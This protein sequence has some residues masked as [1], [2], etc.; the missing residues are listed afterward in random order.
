MLLN[1]RSLV[2]AQDHKYWT[3]G[4]D[5]IQKSSLLTIT[6]RRVVFEPRVYATI[7]KHST[8]FQTVSLS[9]LTISDKENNERFKTKV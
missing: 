5:K 1:K 7:N 2:L 9:S 3:A 4:E 6:P 8:K